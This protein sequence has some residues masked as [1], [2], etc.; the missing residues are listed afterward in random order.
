[1]NRSDIPIASP[2]H[3][4]WSTMSLADRGRFCGA[5]R[6]VV[7]ELRQM[8]ENEARALLASPPTEGLCVRYVHDATG[9]ILFRRD[10]VIPAGKLLRRTAA[11]VAL[12][13]LPMGTVACMGAAPALTGSPPAVPVAS[14]ASA[15]PPP[16]VVMGAP[17][18]M[19]PAPAPK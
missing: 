10:D 12:A 1:M 13:V 16:P 8:T 2:C 7:R 11:V 4:D 6:K 9:E 17:P 3:A 19:Q 5:C 15:A 18:P 14:S